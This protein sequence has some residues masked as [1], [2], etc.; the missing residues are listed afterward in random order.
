MKKIFTLILSLALL[1]AFGQTPAIVMQVVSS[2]GGYA[3]DQTSGL[4]ISWTLGEPVIETLTNSTANLMITQG[5]QQGNLFMV[6]APNP[7][8]PSHRSPC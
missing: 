7:E 3:K 2:S 4:N 8:L 5:F 6:N 1:Q